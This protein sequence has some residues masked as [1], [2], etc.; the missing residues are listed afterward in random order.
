MGAFDN[1]TFDSVSASLRELEV[2]AW[3]IRWIDFMI[4]HGKVQV[5]L[6]GATVERVIRKGNPQ[7]GILSPL[8]WNCVLNPLLKEFQKQCLYAQAYAD[9]LA[10]L[11]ASANISQVRSMGQKAVNITAEWEQKMHFNSAVQKLKL[12]YSPGKEKLL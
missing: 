3:L 8:L 6:C 2:P 12:Y 7:G 5:E 9:D 10:V 1:V 11:V 4:R